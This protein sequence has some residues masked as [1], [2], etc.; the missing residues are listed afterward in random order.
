[1]A[2]YYE[3]NGDRM[4]DPE[5]EFIRLNDYW[6]P[7]AITQSPVGRYACYVDC[8]GA[9]QPTSIMPRGQADLARFANLLLGNIRQQQGIRPGQAL[10]LEAA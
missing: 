1:M 3:Q 5:I 2:H 9:G 8:D 10:P 6:A 7:V 4:S